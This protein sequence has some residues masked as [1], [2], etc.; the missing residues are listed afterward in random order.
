VYPAPVADLGGLAGLLALGESSAEGVLLV[1]S[2]AIAGDPGESTAKIML[3]D[4]M[5]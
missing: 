1:R 5:M 2:K 3:S 4:I